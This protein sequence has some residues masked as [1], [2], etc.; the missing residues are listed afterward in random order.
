M[1]D[2]KA[3]PRVDVAAD[4]ISNKARIERA[5][6]VAGVAPQTPRYQGDVAF[7]QSIDRLIQG[8]SDL[9][10]AEKDV[11]AAELALAN[12]R[13]V[14]DAQQDAYDKAHAVC[15]KL[16]DGGS[17]TPADVTQYGFSVFE[18]KPRGL[19]M[20]NNIRLKYD[21]VKEILRIHVWYPSGRHTCAI[22][23][24]PAPYSEATFQ[25][26]EGNGVTR[27]LRGYAPGTWW[28]RAATTLGAQ[29]SEWFGPVAVIVK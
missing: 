13:V 23:I 25:R 8:G 22:E 14:R 15:A 16:I 3:T 24:S 21:P 28:V 17:R 20:P 18:E 4:R 5:M 10:N 2:T 12:A 29:R 26:L 19:E 7:K 1:A 11:A 9:E 6:G 27:A